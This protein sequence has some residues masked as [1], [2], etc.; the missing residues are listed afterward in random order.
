VS[1]PFDAVPGDGVVVSAVDQRPAAC[2]NDDETPAG[3]FGQ[4]RRQSP[5]P[6]TPDSLDSLLGVGDAVGVA[7]VRIAVT[8]RSGDRFAV[9]IDGARAHFDPLLPTLCVL[10]PAACGG[11]QGPLPG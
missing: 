9:R 11:L 2:A 1:R 5:A 6:N 10:V 3:C 7:G 4:V 8:G